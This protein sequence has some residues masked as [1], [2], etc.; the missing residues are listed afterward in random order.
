MNGAPF[1][2]VLHMKKDVHAKFGNTCL[3]FWGRYQHYKFLSII[4]QSHIIHTLQCIFYI[5]SFYISTPPVTCLQCSTRPSCWF[6]ASVFYWVIQLQCCSKQDCSSWLLQAPSVSVFLSSGNICS[7]HLLQEAGF[8]SALHHMCS[9]VGM[10]FPQQKRIHHTDATF[11]GQQ[12]IQ[13]VW[14]PKCYRL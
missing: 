11:Q 3:K 12:C 2:I 9:C 4:N 1:Y 10:H 7:A 8:V 13:E 14:F 5:E 6:H